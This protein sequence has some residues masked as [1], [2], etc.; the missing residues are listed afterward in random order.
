MARREGTQREISY[1][2]NGVRRVH[3]IDISRTPIQEDKTDSGQMMR[4]GS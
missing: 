1:R 3:M 4:W 2:K